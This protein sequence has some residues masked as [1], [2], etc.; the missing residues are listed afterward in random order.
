MI[1][2]L[3]FVTA[4]SV[5]FFGD[6][7]MKE[8]VERYIPVKGGESERELAGSLLSIKRHHNRGLALNIGESRQPL[9]AVLSLVMTALLTLVFLV[10]LGR[11]GNHLLRAGL[12]LL[13][14]GAFS[15]TY[16]RLKRKYVVD[17]IG[18]GTLI[19]NISDFCIII[20]ALLAA[21]GAF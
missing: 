7:Y 20:G 19:F 4:V 18:I 6:L 16:D 15:N 9:V 14:G 1:A 13:L 3:C 11:R 10:S 21:L 2:A 5:I 8:R 17:Y 12:S